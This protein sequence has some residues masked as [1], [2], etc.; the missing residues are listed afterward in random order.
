MSEK[1]S[2]KKFFFFFLKFLLAAAVLYILFKRSSDEITDCFRN[3]DPVYLVPAVFVSFLQYIFSS[4]RW[5]V[6]AGVAGVE[7]SF[8]EA[9]SLTMQ[10]NFF[11]LVIPGGAIG[12]DVVKMGVLSGSR[13]S[14][15]RFEG[16]F[17]IL[18]DRI[19]GMLS[20]FSLTLLLLV[21]AIP[22][23]LKIRFSTFPPEKSVN[24]VFIAG[25][26]LICLLGTAAGVGIFFHRIL[27]KIPGVRFLM[28]KA[29]YFSGGMVSRM[30][31]AAECYAGAWKY[32]LLLTLLTTFMVHLMAVVPYCLILIGLGVEFS[33]F[34]VIVAAVIGNIAGLI[35]FFPG[36]IG[37]RDLVA[38]TILAAGGMAAGDAKTAQL[39]STAL[40]LVCNLTGGIFFIS[41]T[42]RKCIGEGG[43]NER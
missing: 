7:L 29:E 13:S 28:D 2:M 34:H 5:K 38:I 12:G 21:P 22:M 16:V 37:I 11:S 4:W 36:G 10:G 20:L 3:F 6:L 41:G 17:S 32:L 24:I 15:S 26:A 31:A 39:I 18:A 43:N 19:V 27:Q 9:F 30:T 1:N 25:I 14:G 23:L 35:P 40:M 33:I 42:G 8:F